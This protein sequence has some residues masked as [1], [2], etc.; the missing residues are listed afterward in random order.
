MS[1]KQVVAVVT[2]MSLG[3]VLLLFFAPIG[4]GA[5]KWCAVDV[6]VTGTYHYDG[7][8]TWLSGVQMQTSE[9]SCTI[10]PAGALAFDIF[11]SNFH[12][13][14]TASPGGATAQGDVSIPALTVTVPFSAQAVIDLQPGTYTLTWSSPLPIGGLS[15]GI[16]LCGPATTSTQVTVT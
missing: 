4:V 7:A 13:T 15:C 8:Y 3:A 9:G 14:L 5:S 2:A 6:T 10:L 11:P 12:Y 1:E 16:G